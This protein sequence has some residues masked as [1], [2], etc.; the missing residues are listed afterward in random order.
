MT[1]VDKEPP[2]ASPIANGSAHHIPN[3]DHSALSA[4]AAPRSATTTS[5]ATQ[6][7]CPDPDDHH[8]HKCPDNDS[9]RS[10]D[11]DPTISGGGSSN[12]NSNSNNSNNDGGDSGDEHKERSEQKADAVPLLKTGMLQHHEISS[13]TVLE[14]EITSNCIPLSWSNCDAAS[15]N[16]R[17]GPNYVSGQKSPSL[18]ALYT[19]FAVDA[20]TTSCKINKIWKFIDIESAIA[21]HSALQPAYSEAF[22]LPPLFVLNFMIPNYPPELMGGKDDGE[23]LAVVVYAHL[24]SEIR[25]ELAAFAEDPQRGTLRPA[26]HLLTRF[27]HS[28]LVHSELRNRFKVIARI[29]NPKHT[30]FG[31]VANKLVARYNGKPFLARTSSTFYH[32]KGRYFGVDIDVHRFGY[33]AR[34]GLSYVKDTIQEAVYDI[35]FTIEGHS[36]EELPE[37]ILACCRCSKMGFEVC[38]PFPEQF[39]RRF[40]EE[41]EA[42]EE[43]ERERL[44][45]LPEQQ[46]GDAVDGDEAESASASSLKRLSLKS[47]TPST[48]LSGSIYKDQ[49]GKTAKRPASA[50]AAATENKKKGGRTASWGWGGY[51]GGQ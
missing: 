47:L 31:F 25:D 38:K 29:M 24:S 39:M 35:G 46:S 41:K 34:Q 6:N 28:D 45:R 23:G 44:Q 43:A 27:I 21:K 3:G 18:K 22:P 17:R 19:I 7:G 50:T 20:Y 32:E 48:L 16:V 40:I 33:P 37:Q 26:V 12:S 1:S 2:S 49:N 36:N 30:D 8:D 14:S 5:T 10:N 13:F 11:R 42:A 4:P 15:F 51:F 9:H